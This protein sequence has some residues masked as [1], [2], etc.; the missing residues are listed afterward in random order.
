MRM[1][2]EIFNNLIWFILHFLK[3]DYIFLITKKG[4]VCA[5]V[6]KP[7]PV[8]KIL[9]IDYTKFKV[10]LSFRAPINTC[11]P[12][13]FSNTLHLLFKLRTQFTPYVASKVKIWL[14]CHLHPSGTP[15]I[16]LN[17]TQFRKLKYEFFPCVRMLNNKHFFSIHIHICM[18]FRT[19]TI[20]TTTN[21]FL[22]SKPSKTTSSLKKSC[23][24]TTILAS[25]DSAD[26]SLILMQR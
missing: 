9:K 21:F 4:T 12:C 14:F 1:E 19:E 5:S 8:T 11:T 25:R 6:H 2:R 26:T 13:N 20:H 22:H 10:R 23:F 7:R 3:K 16:F 15:M 17:E 18:D 24:E